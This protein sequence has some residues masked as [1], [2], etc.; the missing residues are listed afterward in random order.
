MIYG[1]S[2]FM[3]DT[4]ERIEVS[5]L[6]IKIANGFIY[7]GI[8]YPWHSTNRHTHTHTR[9]FQLTCSSI[10]NYQLK[11]MVCVCVAVC[12]RKFRLRSYQF[13]IVAVRWRF[14]T[15][16][17]EPTDDIRVSNA[18]RRIYIKQL[19][20]NQILHPKHRDN[21]KPRSPSSSS[22]ALEGGGGGIMLN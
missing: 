7:G 13:R 4:R 1:H 15:K 2:I 3:V 20:N 17:F 22:S 11:S 6:I 14:D 16:C 9:L 18:C 19:T 8:A 21:V 10:M 5:F 12:T